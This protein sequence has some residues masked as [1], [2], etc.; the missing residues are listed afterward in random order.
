MD[1]KCCEFVQKIIHRAPAF[2]NDFYINR[3]V[4]YQMQPKSTYALFLTQ[5][6]PEEV[7][8]VSANQNKGPQKKP[9]A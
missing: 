2:E 5:K 7:K 4:S 8:I 6:D 9:S 1:Y 3:L